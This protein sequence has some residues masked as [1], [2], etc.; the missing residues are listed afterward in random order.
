[1]HS[2][3]PPHAHRPSEPIYAPLA[4]PIGDIPF[5]REW[6]GGGTPKDSPRFNGP[7]LG[8]QIS[9]WLGASATSAPANPPAL[10]FDSQE[11]TG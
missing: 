3:T 7:Q 9:S 10:S 5:F 1:M 8:P 4:H 6:I 11:N 2:H